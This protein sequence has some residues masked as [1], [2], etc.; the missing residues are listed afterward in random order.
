[1][2]CKVTVSMTTVSL[3]VGQEVILLVTTL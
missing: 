2:V 3:T 1:L